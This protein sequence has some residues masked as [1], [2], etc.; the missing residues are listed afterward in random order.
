MKTKTL[1]AIAALLATGGIALGQDLGNP[2]SS[3]PYDRYLGPMRTTLSD[4]GG[5]KPPV[6]IVKGYVRTAK[7]FRYYMKTPY[8]PQTPAQTE[9]SHSGDCKAKSLW[10][11][12][13]MDDRSVRFVIGKARANSGM[14]HAWLLWKSPSGWLILDPT[15]FS[16]PLSVN[17]V[18]GNE[19]IAQ[20][21]YTAGG[22]FVHAGASASKRRQSAKYGDHT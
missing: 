3:T 13:K 20:Y 8:V 6:N 5:N 4:L 10:V 14:S 17:R 15:N 2:T 12:F 19:F 1:L 22:K 7:G 9:A 18:G 16:S 11:A 21:S